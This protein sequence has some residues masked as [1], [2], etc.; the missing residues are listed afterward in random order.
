MENRS[1]RIMVLKRA[2]IGHHVLSVAL[3]LH[4][5]Q[6]CVSQCSNSIDFFSEAVMLNNSF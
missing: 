3:S 2:K 1:A 5:L 6:V 4:M